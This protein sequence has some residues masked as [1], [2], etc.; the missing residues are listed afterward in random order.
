MG[1]YITRACYPDVCCAGG[2]VR[3]T[4]PRSKEKLKSRLIDFFANKVVFH[5][6][7]YKCE[8]ELMY[9]SF[10]DLRATIN[11]IAY[12]K[13][14]YIEEPIEADIQVPVDDLDSLRNIHVALK[15]RKSL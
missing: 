9:S 5:S 6:E 7:T 1:V 8:P 10:V 11:K 12:M 2:H 15:L 3:L 14:Q 13:R 4:S